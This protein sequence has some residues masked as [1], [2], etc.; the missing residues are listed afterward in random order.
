V[1]SVR[2]SGRDYAYAAA[3]ERQ[4]AQLLGDQV[5]GKPGGISRVGAPGSFAQYEKARLVENTRRH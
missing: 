3:Y 5:A 4:Y 2:S 1:E